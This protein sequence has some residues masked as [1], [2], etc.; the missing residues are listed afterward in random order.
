MKGGVTQME[1]RTSDR[2]FTSGQGVISCQ[3]GSWCRVEQFRADLK[4]VQPS[5]QQI[6]NQLGLLL[7]EEALLCKV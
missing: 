6:L 1:I 2:M 3:L 4:A 5:F 7:I